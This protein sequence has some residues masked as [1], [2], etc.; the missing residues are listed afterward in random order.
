MQSILEK[1][2]KIEDI[3]AEPL[4]TTE[5]SKPVEQDP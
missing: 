2:Q 5:V 1:R 3:R 4:E